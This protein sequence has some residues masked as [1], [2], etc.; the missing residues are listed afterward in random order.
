MRRTWKVALAVASLAGW[1]PLRAARAADMDPAPE[2]LFLEP[3]NLPSGT[4]CQGIAQNPQAFIDGHPGL[5]PGS[6][7][8]LPNNIA[9]ANLMSELGYALAPSAFHPART[10]GFGGFAFSIEASFAHINADAVDSTGTPYWRAGTEGPG[11]PGSHQVSVV[12]KNPDSIL[13]IYSLNI[14]KGLPFGLEVAGVVG[15]VAKTSLWVGG[16]D[17][18]WA[19]FEGY[20]TGVLGYLPDVAIG[21]GVRTLEGLSKFSLTTVGMDAQLSKPL[22]VADSAVVTP[23]L[24]AQRLIIF[25]DSAVVDSTP[26]VDPLRQCGY[27]GRDPQT[28]APVCSNKLNT[29][30]S[31]TT[32]N[33][34]DF[35]NDAAFQ[36][37]RMH[38]W[39]AIAGLTYRYD[40]L[41]LGAQVV[42]DFE[43][44]SAE[45]SS[46]GVSGSR[47]WTVS[48]ETGVAF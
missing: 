11:D 1:A 15:I 18:T 20:R 27:Q 39:R 30:P 16:A 34:G 13:Q 24:G 35:N 31:A 17:L 22:A 37:A 41:L 45:N 28:G 21:A 46:L 44:P 32:D 10:A 5:S 6:F 40:I 3:K 33:N 14:R 29:G 43:D 48:L 4:S 42:M 19:L 36:T 2:R 47:Q 25:A 23:Y 8:C 9:W 7:P 26:S 12:N 38:R